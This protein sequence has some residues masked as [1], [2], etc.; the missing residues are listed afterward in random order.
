MKMNGYSLPV[1]VF[2]VKKNSSLTRLEISLTGR[3]NGLGRYSKCANWSSRIPDPSRRPAAAVHRLWQT[4]CSVRHNG[5][6]VI[7]NIRQHVGLTTCLPCTTADTRTTS[8]PYQKISAQN[9]P[10]KRQRCVARSASRAAR[11]SALPPAQTAVPAPTTALASAFNKRAT[12]VN[13]LLHL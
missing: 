12:I 5:H 6:R 1:Q 8:L 3:E 2:S 7:S 13:E 11:S 10:C 9:A 4:A